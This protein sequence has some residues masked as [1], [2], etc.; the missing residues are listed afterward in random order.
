MSHRR[1][2]ISKTVEYDT[3]ICIHCSDEVFIDESVENID[4]LPQGI[5]VVIGGGER[6]STDS[7]PFG[8]RLKNYRVPRVIIKWFSGDSREN[9]SSIQYMCPS[10]AKSV[11]DFQTNE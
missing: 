11:Y 3:D 9:T 1:T 10:C 5:T 8:A 6:I 2:A 4:G 7:T